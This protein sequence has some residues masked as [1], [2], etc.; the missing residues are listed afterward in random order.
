V[1]HDRSERPQPVPLQ[2]GLDAI[3]RSLKADA[4]TV[5]TVFSGWDE[6]VGPVIAAHARPVKL[7]GPVLLVEVDEVI[8]AHARPVKLDGPVLLVEVD[9]PGWATQLKYLQ[10]DVLQRLRQF[11]GGPIERL[12]VRVAGAAHQRKRPVRGRRPS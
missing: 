6:A 12:E 1:I 8:A 3:V 9:E 7:D 2:S 11:G 4:A 10:S 5:R